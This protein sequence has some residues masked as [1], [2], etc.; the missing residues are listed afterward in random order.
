MMV[1]KAVNM[2][3]KEERKGEK[4]KD[5]EKG[6]AIV[7]AAL[8][9]NKNGIGRLIYTHCTHPPIPP[10]D[11]LLHAGD[12][13]KWGTFSEI[14]AQLTWLSEQPH[15]Y[16]VVVAGNHDLLLDPEFREQHP[17]RWKKSAQAASDDNNINYVDYQAAHLDWADVI[18]LHNSSVTLPFTCDRSLRI[19]G[20]PLT[21]RYGLSAFQHLPSEDVWTEKVPLNTDIVLT[22][23]PPRGHLDGF[24]K[25]GCA[26]LTQEVLRVQPRLVV[27]G[28]IHEGYGTEERVYDRVGEAYEQ[29]FGQL[30]GWVNLASM[31]WGIMWGYLIPRSLQQPERRTAFVNAAVVEGWENYMVKNE[32]VVLQI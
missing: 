5:P 17:E 28:H 25:S 7:N 20:S 29:I 22:H 9:G 21:P 32:A 18:Y 4:L 6:S 15:K 30:G 13:S 27:Y 1:A 8:S 31:A 10:G 2:L 24:M 14:Q 3:L 11:L 26:F 23:G 12:L 16:K 19:Y